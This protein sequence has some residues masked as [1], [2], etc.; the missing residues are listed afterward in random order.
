MYRKHDADLCEVPIGQG[1]SEGTKIL[2]RH[3]TASIELASHHDPRAEVVAGTIFLGWDE[4][5]RF[6]GWS[7]GNRELI[8]LDQVESI[9]RFP[10]VE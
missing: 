1:G 5:L 8:L 7:R 6:L 3:G 2:S 9:G 10:N 4:I